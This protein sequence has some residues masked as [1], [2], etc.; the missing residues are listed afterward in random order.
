[1]LRWKRPAGGTFI[2]GY[3][4]ERTREGR[5]YETLGETGRLVFY[6]RNIPLDDPWFYRVTAF[7]IRGD[8]GARLVW[9]FRQ[10]SSGEILLLPIA[11]VP[12]LRVNIWL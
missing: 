6:V 11:V 10:S 9:L 5:N 12:D 8:G 7:N 3:R 1:M 2:S 4:I